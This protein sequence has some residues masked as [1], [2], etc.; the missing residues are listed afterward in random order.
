MNASVFKRL[1]S[2][3]IDAII[4]ISITVFL[5]RVIARPLIEQ[6]IDN[7]DTL[8]STF[9]EAQ[10]QRFND[11]LL[12][13]ENFDSGLISEEAYQNQLNEI[14]Q[15][16]NDT[17]TEETNAYATF[18]VSSGVY[19]L[20]VLSLI[21]YF[22][23]VATNGKTIGRRMNK[24]RLSGPVNWWTL[25]LREFFWKSVYWTFTLG[26]GFFLDFIL[27]SLTQQR[28]TIRDYLSRI[29]VVVEDTLYPI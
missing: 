26:F 25:L 2:F 15:I 9:I 11:V 28:K 8:Y 27:I 21:N 1:F 3:I 12:I 29:H 20:A 17:Y 18:L 10:D 4:I 14:D 7:F 23:Q 5:Y 22:Y 24:L 6:S 13:Q 19:F 16:Y